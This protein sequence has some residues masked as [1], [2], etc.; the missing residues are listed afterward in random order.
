MNLLKDKKHIFFTGIGGIGMSGIAE[1]LLARGF[2]VSGSDKQPSEIT[3]YLAG[4]GA[5]FYQG[6]AAGNLKEVDLLV[7]SSAVP[8]SNPERRQADTLGITQVRRAEML[9]D[10][11][12]NHFNIAIAGTHGKTTT[13]ALCSQI[14]I[15]AD[16]D[17]TVVIGGKLRNLKTNARLGK[18]KHFITEADEYDR[19][20]LALSPNIAIITTIE[21]DHLDCYRDLADIDDTFL[22][23]AKKV[24]ADGHIICCVDDPGV[25]RIILQLDR[26]VSTYGFSERADFQAINLSFHN[27]QSGF[28]IALAGKVLARISLQIPGRHNVLNATAAFAAAT[29]AGISPGTIAGALGRF[30]GVNRRFELK[31]EVENILIFDDYA[32]HPTEVAA[33]LNSAKAGWNRKVIVIFQPHLFSRTRDFYKE[34]ARSLSIADE[35]ILADI[36]PAREEPIPGVTSTLIIDEARQQGWNQF[37]YFRE[38]EAIEDYLL[39]HLAP[40]DLLITMG[41]GDIWQLGESLVTKLQKQ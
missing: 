37:S 8:V 15:E 22:T 5:Q 28:E 13:T 33:T 9:A 21:A 31:G 18:G 39:A 3:S 12:T 23:F 1:I 10:I 32:H 29:L 11:M 35:V 25:Q 20:F 19:S 36:Y 26:P 40:E 7:Y 24:P 30:T 2:R 17:P 34:F 16:L 38:K 27:N 14:F 41:A 6:H 4:K